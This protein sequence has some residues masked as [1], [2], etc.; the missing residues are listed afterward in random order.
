MERKGGEEENSERERKIEDDRVW[1]G[2]KEKKR[3]RI[4]KEKEE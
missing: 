2:K 3:K 1:K 4:G